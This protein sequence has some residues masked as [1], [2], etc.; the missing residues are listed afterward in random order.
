MW[1][2]GKLNI[3]LPTV[4]PKS[5]L[6][7]HGC[8]SKTQVQA[9]ASHTPSRTPYDAHPREPKTCRSNT[10]PLSASE[11]LTQ[12]ASTGWTIRSAHLGNRDMLWLGRS[13]VVALHSRGFEWRKLTETIR[14]VYFYQPSIKRITANVYSDIFFNNHKPF[15]FTLT[16]SSGKN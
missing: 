10:T 6:G 3:S 5:D 1:I 11:L 8:L 13:W 15:L 2:G 9:Q 12:I 14:A 7:V 16:K 4:Q